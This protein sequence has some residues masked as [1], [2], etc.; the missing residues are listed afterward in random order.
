MCKK[1]AYNHSG[2]NELVI[3]TINPF[4][5]MKT[6]KREGR[7]ESPLVSYLS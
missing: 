5:Y 4:Y 7:K 1:T 2:I 6:I 3:V